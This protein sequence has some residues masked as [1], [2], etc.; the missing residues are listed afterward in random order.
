MI[1]KRTLTVLMWIVVLFTAPAIWFVWCQ[2]RAWD[3]SE[4]AYDLTRRER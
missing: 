2:V 4:R 3:R 1:D